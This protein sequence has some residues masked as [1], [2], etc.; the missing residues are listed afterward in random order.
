MT[1]IEQEEKRFGELIRRFEKIWH[2]SL[3]CNFN[4]LEADDQYTLYSF[5]VEM[6]EMRHIRHL[7]EGKPIDTDGYPILFGS[8]KGSFYDVIKEANDRLEAKLNGKV[9]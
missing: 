8:G 3:K 9:E 6:P 1:T 7:K 5:C 4:L 2:I